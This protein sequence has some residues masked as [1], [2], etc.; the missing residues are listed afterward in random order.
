MYIYLARQQEV[1]KSGPAVYNAPPLISHNAFQYTFLG[2]RRGVVVLLRASEREVWS[3]KRFRN[4]SGMRLEGHPEFKVVR[5]S[6]TK[7]AS[8]ANV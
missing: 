7:S 1:R 3:S 8:K 6:S 4:T 2:S 5:C